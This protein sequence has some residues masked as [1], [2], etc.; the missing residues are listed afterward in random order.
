MRLRYFHIRNY[1]PLED[2]EI[3]FSAKSPLNT[4]NAIHFVVGIN[5]SGKTHLLQALTETFLC[6]ERRKT[7]SFP[8]TLIYELGKE[9]KRTY[10]FD[11]AHDEAKTNWWQLSENLALPPE[12]STEYFRKT[13]DD[14]RNSSN[15]GWAALIRD[16]NWPGSGEKVGLPVSVLTY[17]TGLTAGWYEL[18]REEQRAD[19]INFDNGQEERPHGWSL[20]QEEAAFPGTVTGDVEQT[21]LL[22]Q[23][24]IKFCQ[25]VTPFMLKLAVLAVTLNLAL[26]ELKQHLTDDERNAFIQTIKDKKENSG[27]RALL[28]Q[29][30]WVWPVSIVME[31]QPTSEMN[32]PENHSSGALFWRKSLEASTVVLTEP[33]PSRKHRIIFDLGNRKK[34]T[35]LRELFDLSKTPFSIFQQLLKMHDVGVLDSLTIGLRKA[36]TEDILLFDELSDGEQMYLGRMA[37]FHLLEEQDDALLL[38][39]EPETHFNDRWKR[40]LV[41][42]IDQVIGKQ[43]NHVLISTHSGIT[44]TDVFTDEITVI[45]KDKSGSPRHK[46]LEGIHTFGATPDHPLRDVFG[47]PGTVGKR[48]SALLD[49]LLL[50][51]PN[52]EIVEQYWH[53]ETGVEVRKRLSSQFVQAVNTYPEFENKYSES[54]ITTILETLSKVA[55]EQVDQPTVAAVAKYFA[56]IVGPGYYQFDLYQA[57]Y[58]L[59]RKGQ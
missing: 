58:E 47:A 6:L 51:E 32:D 40:D 42:I 26:D 3:V 10:V 16:G 38:L 20:E 7:P 59:T 14:V 36:D 21:S 43:A 35:L 45:E 11:H 30:G 57:V 54:R 55:N 13:L 28:S 25:F 48:A 46:I 5:G 37:L 23:V 1:P 50:C 12:A 34:E 24:E 15:S 31:C 8:V 53:P 39:D 22:D 56:D 2:L 18:F 27:L 9:K 52:K 4:T 19:N 29:V 33:D 49:V 41:D 44:L 17:T